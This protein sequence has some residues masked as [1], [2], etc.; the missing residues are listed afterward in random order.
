MFRLLVLLFCYAALIPSANA[1]SQQIALVIGVGNYKTISPLRNPPRDARAVA[2]KLRGLGFQT[3]LVIDPDRAALERA[4]RDVGDN[5]RAATAVLVY[6]AGHALETG[7]QNYLVPASAKISSVRDVPFETVALDLIPAQLEG[8]TRTL[9]IF[10]DACRDN[11]FASRI[12]TGQ[13][14]IT[15]RGLAPPS[16]NATGTLV[17]YATA[18]GQTA[19]DGAGDDSPFTTALLRYI[20]APGLEVRQ[21]LSRVRRDVRDATKGAQI[22]W[23]SSSLEGDFYFRPPL[24]AGVSPLPS[25]AAGPP[26]PAAQAGPTSPPFQV[27]TTPQS[28]TPASTA[29]TSPRAAA[30][31]LAPPPTNLT[32]PQ[33]QVATAPQSI[34]SSPTRVD[35]ACYTTP[36]RGIDT[37]AG[38]VA[39]MRVVNNGKP[40]SV[41]LTRGPGRSYDEL[42]LTKEPKH[43]IVAI[44]GSSFYYTPSTGFTGTDTFTITASPV[45]LVTASVSV[46]PP[47]A[48]QE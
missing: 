29:Q 38:A 47:E 5:G 37:A 28:P 44:N 16:A 2:A 10:L 7:G 13:R 36:F 40:C 30:V 1:Q 43:G 26:R 23:E 11:P 17:V 21:I 27:T 24:A 19:D 6:Y 39:F 3:D 34:T 18:P 9:M 8:R 15:A 42:F 12:A 35:K 48:L 14:G 20:D 4:I 32:P 33:F 22:P 31:P 46:L 41:R 25:P 45:A